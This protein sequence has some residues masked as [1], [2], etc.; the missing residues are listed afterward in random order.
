RMAEAL[1]AG[2]GVNA[3]GGLSLAVKAMKGDDTRMDEDSLYATLL[4]RFVHEK[5]LSRDETY[6]QALSD[7]AGHL[8]DRDLRNISDGHLTL[9]YVDESVHG[10]LNI[11]QVRKSWAEFTTQVHLWDADE[12]ARRVRRLP[13]KSDDSPLR[14]WAWLH[15][16]SAGRRAA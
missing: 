6:E 3:D 14:A 12:A 8:R 13:G 16:T 4:K 1:S 11:E 5:L 10:Q 2:V 15:L 9:L 7:F